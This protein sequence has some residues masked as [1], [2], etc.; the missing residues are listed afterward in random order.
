[1]KFLIL[2]LTFVFFFGSSIAQDSSKSNL[3]QLVTAN[4][5]SE[6]KVLP[7]RKVLSLKNKGFIS[8]INPVTYLSAGL[9][10]VY[11]RTLSEQIQAECMYQT[12]CSSYTKLQMEQNG[13]RGFLLGFHQ[14]NNC[15]ASAI[16]DYPSCMISNENKVINTVNKIGR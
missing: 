11:Q 10:F 15:V 9:L 6:Y 12:S 16:D 8:K 13:F 7:K 2:L 1:M 4:F 5:Y 3:N 14:L